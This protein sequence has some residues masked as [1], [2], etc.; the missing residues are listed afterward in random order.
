MVYTITFSP[1]LD[2]VLRL[3]QLSGEDIHR[4]DSAAIFCGGKG[5]NVSMVLSQLEI[6]TKALG[7]IA[8]FTGR[9]LERRLQADG[10]QTDFVHLQTGVTRI[11]VK[12]FA[13]TQMDI[14]AP[15]AVPDADALNR[16]F[17]KLEQLQSGDYLVLAGAVPGG[18]PENIYEKVLEQI[19]GKGIRT[20]VDTTGNYL[21][22]VLKYKPF[23][24]KPNHHE[25]AEIFHAD[26]GADD[27]KKIV[28]YAKKLQKMGAGNVLVSRGKYGAT[29]VDEN[30]EVLTTGIVPGK[31]V[32]NVGC[33]DSM[34]AGFIAGYIQTKDS[35]E[36]LNLASAAG[37]ASAFCE[38]V[39]K[40]ADIL[41]IKNEFFSHAGRVQN[42]N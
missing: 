35:A 21:L 22:S 11:N 14:N 36:A 38:G 25:L 41:K 42:E 23:L 5:I 15:G 13:E 32:N 17:H 37:N 40:K 30:G 6:K 26:I 31:S 19:Q 28:Q 18:I 3:K 20:V 10:I 29:L 9:E 16:L 8:G 4:A 1:A 24:I 12:I 2:Y 33:G 27:E 7:F 39:A 34:V